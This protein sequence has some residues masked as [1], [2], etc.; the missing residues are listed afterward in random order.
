MAEC[1]RLDGIGV[2]RTVVGGVLLGIGMMCGLRRLRHGN[3]AAS[4]PVCVAGIQR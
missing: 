3:L 4:I 1:S 2:F